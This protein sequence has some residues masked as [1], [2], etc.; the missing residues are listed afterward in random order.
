MHT[1]IVEINYKLCLQ[2]NTEQ[3]NNYLYAIRSYCK[4]YTYPQHK[5]TSFN[6]NH[7]I[8]M[9]DKRMKPAAAQQFIE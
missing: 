7:S 9:G 2:D 1:N 8:S 6:P 4:I 3:L 5:Y